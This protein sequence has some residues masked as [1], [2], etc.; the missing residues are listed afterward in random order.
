VLGALVVVLARVAAGGD[1][2]DFYVPGPDFVQSGADQN[3]R[4]RRETA[5]ARVWSPR[6]CYRPS[7]VSAQ[8]AL[9]T[10]YTHTRGD[11]WTNPWDLRSD[12]CLDR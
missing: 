7:L 2:N 5:G 10:L 12:P 1:P 11:L 4:V 6:L 3:E 9:R 8:G